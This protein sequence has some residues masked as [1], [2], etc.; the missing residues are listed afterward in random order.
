MNVHAFMNYLDQ[1]D[2]ISKKNYYC[3][4]SCVKSMESCHRVISHS[5]RV[6]FRE[7]DIHNFA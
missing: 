4:N 3:K 2:L 1:K 5:G 7:G 6:T